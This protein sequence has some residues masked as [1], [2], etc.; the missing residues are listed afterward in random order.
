MTVETLASRRNGP[1]RNA[2]S[3]QWHLRGHTCVIALRTYPKGILAW[4]S[5]PNDD[6]AGAD[7]CWDPSVEWV[8]GTGTVAEAFDEDDEV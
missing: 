4:D 3:I 8:G 1:R 6:D 5:V 7:P 2:L